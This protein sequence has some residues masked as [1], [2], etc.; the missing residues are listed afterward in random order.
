ME[1]TKENGNGKVEQAIVTGMHTAALP[2]VHE[3]GSVE[4]QLKRAEKQIAFRKGIL[5]LI[6]ANINPEKFL[7]RTGSADWHARTW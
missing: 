1:A 7:G 3:E 5:K 6:A 2:A 4:N